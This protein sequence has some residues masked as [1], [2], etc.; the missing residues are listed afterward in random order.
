MMCFIIRYV[1]KD[2]VATVWPSKDLGVVQSHTAYTSQETMALELA[3][4]RVGGHG[5]GREDWMRLREIQEIKSSGLGNGSDM[6]SEGERG[7]WMPDE[8]W[9]T[10]GKNQKG[11]GLGSHEFEACWGISGLTLNGGCINGPG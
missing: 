2:T 1:R 5:G 10:V 11:I 7:F 9:S 4:T 6:R 3:W 8:T